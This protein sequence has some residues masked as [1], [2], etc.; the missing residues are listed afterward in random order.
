LRT[1]K[2]YPAVAAIL[3]VLIAATSCHRSRPQAGASAPDFRL[4]DLTG[5]TVFLNANLH[6][7]VV[8][9]FFAT[10][11]APCREEIPLLVDL[12][13]KYT[14]KVSILCVDVDPENID[15]IH[16][17]A[18]GLSIPYPFLL[19]EGRRTMDRYGVREL[20]ATFLIDTN[21]RILSKYGMLNETGLR[22]LSEQ[23]ERL[24]SAPHG[25]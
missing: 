13:L 12:N 15:K 11:C 7:P 24:A 8:L 4:N 10:W 5:R 17:I 3:A 25:N 16:S 20:P 1:A 21:G 2:P 6:T 19:D 9:T 18:S 23:I 22:S 14:G